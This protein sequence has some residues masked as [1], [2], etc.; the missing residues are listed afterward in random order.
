[1]AKRKKNKGNV[2]PLTLW[3]VH[4]STGVPGE[5]VTLEVQC[6]TREHAASVFRDRYPKGYVYSTYS[7]GTS[8]G[9]APANTK[10][11]PEYANPFTEAVFVALGREPETTTQ[12]KKV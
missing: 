7:T 6:Q 2:K 3:H 5:S 10:P 1:M 9:K 8:S 12:L 11:L 4:G